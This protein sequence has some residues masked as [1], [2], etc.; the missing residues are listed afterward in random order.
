VLL[1]AAAERTGDAETVLAAAE[2]LGVAAEAAGAAE[3]AGLAGVAGG[4]AGFRHPLVRAAVYLGATLTRRLAVLGPLVGVLGAA[5]EA[6]AEGGDFG[7]A[8]ELAARGAAVSGDP[9]AVARLA[10]VRARAE[11]AEGRLL[12]AHRLLAEGAAGIGGADPLR[13]A[14]MLTYAVHV[15]WL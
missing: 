1:V 2:A 4:V 7:R 11:V 6:A 10:C 5:R 14:R 8:R 15:A 13:A 12:A 9:V 3:R